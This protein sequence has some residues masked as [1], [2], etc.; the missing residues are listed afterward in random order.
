MNIMEKYQTLKV[1]LT[2]FL[3]NDADAYGDSYPEIVD[4]AIEMVTGLKADLQ[5]DSAEFV[6]DFSDN[7]SATDY[8]NKLTEGDIGDVSFLRPSPL[9]FVR[10]LSDYLK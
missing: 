2:T 8:L 7:N 9:E 4:T 6:S 10:W 5:S 3:G 1:F